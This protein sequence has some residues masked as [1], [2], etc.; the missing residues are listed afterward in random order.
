MI[1][2]VCTWNVR[3]LYRIRA[4]DISSIT[5]TLGL[6]ICHPILREALKKLYLFIQPSFTTSSNPTSSFPIRKSY[7]ST[8]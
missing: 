6:A 7:W 8:T 3:T 2:V 4:K 5:S 1:N